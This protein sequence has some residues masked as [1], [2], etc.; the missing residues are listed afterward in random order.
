MKS[1]EIKVEQKA[2]QWQLFH[3][4]AGDPSASSVSVPKGDTGLFSYKIVGSSGVKFASDPIWITSGTAK[5]TQT[6]VDA[7]ITNVSSG[8]TNKLT[9]TD[10]NTEAT[11]LTYILRFDDGT[12]TDPIINNGGGGPPPPPPPPP[13]ST[14]SST[15][16]PSPSPQ[17]PATSYGNIALYVGIGVV[18]GFIIAWLVKR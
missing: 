6:G 15:V 16:P 7:Q 10:G 4:Q 1:F 14:S 2:G 13:D 17:P 3:D 8:G 9:F 5:P 11:T 18:I 12:A